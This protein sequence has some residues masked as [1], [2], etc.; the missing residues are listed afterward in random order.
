MT[1]NEFL[2]PRET[3][4]GNLL[5]QGK[6]NKQIA[7]ELH[8]SVRSVEF[9]LSNIYE[10]LGVSSRTEAVLRLAKMDLRK[11]TG[12]QLRQSPVDK[13]G[14]TSENQTKQIVRRNLMRKLAII[15]GSVLLLGVLVV[16]VFLLKRTSGSGQHTPTILQNVSTP[17]SFTQ[18]P[19]TD[20]SAKE[21]LLE[22]IRQLVAEYNQSVQ[23]EKQNGKVEFSKDANTGEDIFR[24]QGESYTKISNLYMQMIE[25]ITELEKLY[26]TIYRDEID[27]T[28]FPTQ[29]SSEQDKAYYQMLMGQADEYCSLQSWEK[30]KQAQTVMAYDPDEGKY[31]AFYTG[32]TIARCEVYGQM[33]EEYRTAPF[34][35]KVNQTN[36]I[37]MIDL[38]AGNPE[39]RLTFKGISAPA[40]APWRNA[41]LYTDETGTNYYVDIE[42][43]RLVTIESNFPTHPDI[44][45]DQEKSLDE[46][47]AIAGEFAYKNSP[48]LKELENDLEY[49]EGNKG[50]MYFFTWNYRNRDWSGTDWQMMPPFLQIGLL[51]NGKIVGYINTLD[52][53]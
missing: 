45:P 26:T 51:A 17:I 9:H 29:A 22:Q 7:V 8:I 48:R 4:V 14:E 44:A 6:S 34:L 50:H 20:H 21:R 35:A 16:S 43:S 15:V 25:K 30:D 10:K 19:T 52:L 49:E 47:R 41:A 36:D 28:P 31:R 1:K 38:I 5:L 12:D 24:F 37:R 33:L 32:D 23:A 42:T 3:E 53:Y 2:S 18:S 39:L 27:P 13:L 11:T 46:L 40:N